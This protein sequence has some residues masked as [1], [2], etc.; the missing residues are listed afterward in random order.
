MK[1]RFLSVIIIFTVCILLVG[2]GCQ[3]QKDDIIAENDWYMVNNEM[4][5]VIINECVNY[6]NSINATES[7]CKG[8]EKIEI[9]GEELTFQEAIDGNYFTD[10]QLEY[11]VSQKIIFHHHIAKWLYKIGEF[12][13]PILRVIFGIL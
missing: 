9:N 1:N 12:F 13:W 8:E 3:K 6:L 7:F 2:C 4:D 5:E 10:I 11:L